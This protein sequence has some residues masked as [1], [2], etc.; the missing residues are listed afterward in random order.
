[1]VLGDTKAGSLRQCF[2]YTR[3]VR[4]RIR[5][6]R[7]AYFFSSPSSGGLSQI[8]YLSYIGGFFVRKK[9]GQ[10]R[11]KVL[12]WEKEWGTFSGITNVTIHDDNTNIEPDDNNKCVVNIAICL[13]TLM[14][15][16][17]LRTWNINDTLYIYI[18]TD[19]NELPGQVRVGEEGKVVN[20]S[21][22][23][24]QV[25]LHSD[26]L[27]SYNRLPCSWDRQYEYKATIVYLVMGKAVNL[28]VTTVNNVVRKHNQY[29]NRAIV[30]YL[31]WCR[32]VTS[33]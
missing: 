25:L 30:V 22:E 15:D 16:T 8:P 5:S 17:D 4:L 27:S 28:L 1:M 9:L 26:F 33:F 21:D 12:G 31:F 23:D 29:R 6:A 13:I 19:L 24:S 3:S 11:I 14:F 20:G 10:I 18:Y 2:K 7:L 32:K